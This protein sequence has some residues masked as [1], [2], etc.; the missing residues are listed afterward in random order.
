MWILAFRRN[1]LLQIQDQ[2]AR[3]ESLIFIG[4]GEAIEIVPD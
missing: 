3:K 2:P 4:S 1:I